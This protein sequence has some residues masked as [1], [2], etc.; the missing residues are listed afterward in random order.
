MKYD[1]R[2]EGCFTCHK[3]SLSI[4][5]NPFTGAIGC[6]VQNLVKLFPIEHQ[7]PNLSKQDNTFWLRLIFEVKFHI[8]PFDLWLKEEPLWRSQSESVTPDIYTNNK[9]HNIGFLFMESQQQL[10]FFILN[11][12]SCAFSWIFVIGL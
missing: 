1:S 5:R 4:N 9:C 6:S 3:L 10:A 11:C 2:K 12:I 7:L 8:S